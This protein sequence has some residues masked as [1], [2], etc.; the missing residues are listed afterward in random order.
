[1]PE[2]SAALDTPHTLTNDSLTETEHAE[3]VEIHA[4]AEESAARVT[5]QPEL[6]AAASAATEPAEDIPLPMN[7]STSA[8]TTAPAVAPV[9]DVVASAHPVA[10]AAPLAPEAAED[11]APIPRK[12][13]YKINEVARITK[14]EP[15]VLRYWET[16]FPMLA[17][18]K[19]SGNQRRYR[20][21]DIEMVERIKELLYTEKYTIAGAV[22]KL[23]EEARE[24]RKAGASAPARGG[25]S[26]AARTAPAPATA[27]AAEAPDEASGDLFPAELSAAERAA[28][29]LALAAAAAPSAPVGAGGAILLS[30][31][32]GIS[33]GISSLRKNVRSLIDE[34]RA[35]RE[36]VAN[37]RPAVAPSAPAP[38][39][40]RG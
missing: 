26:A 24:K 37:A 36:S 28:Q 39:E 8:G 32:A 34:T 11:G 4:P 33:E 19:E 38:L 16:K 31:P 27:A 3:A 12:L 5:P 18:G 30:V 6:L 7:A 10:A 9:G 17:P 29:A 40:H 2:G 23:K 13:F 1:M 21:A 20:P 25:K 22:D 14:V 15:Y 35:W